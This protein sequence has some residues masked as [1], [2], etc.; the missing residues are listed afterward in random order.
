MFKQR[1]NA[2]YRS[3]LAALLV[4]AFLTSVI[5]P[6]AD[7][8]WHKNTIKGAA[9][10]AGVGALVGGGSGARKGA[11]VGAIVGAVKK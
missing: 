8:K 5:A 9:I 4:A 3:I 10:G 1:T 6:T 2:H 7:A 11:A